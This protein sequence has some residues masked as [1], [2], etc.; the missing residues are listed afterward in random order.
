MGP[1]YT[2]PIPT[3]DCY[4]VAKYIIE[5]AKEFNADITRM[6]RLYTELK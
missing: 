2:Y 6:V 1:E 3:T 4:T 5:H